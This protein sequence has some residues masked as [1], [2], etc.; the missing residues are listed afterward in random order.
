[1]PYNESTT[2]RP[3]GSKTVRKEYID[4]DTGKCT[5][6]EITEYPPD[7]LDFSV[8]SSSTKQP[9]TTVIIPDDNDD[10]DDEMNKNSGFSSTTM[11]TIGKT[12][13]GKTSTKV[14]KKDQMPSPSIKPIVQIASN[15]RTTTAPLPSQQ[16]KNKNQTPA[17]KE[18]PSA[19]G[20]CCTVQ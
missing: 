11:P 20:C 14:V 17:A 15:Q 1:M 5:K 10:D 9:K 3:D 8:M 16:T 18:Q 2:R 6:V 13:V 7:K 19:N 4:P 12:T